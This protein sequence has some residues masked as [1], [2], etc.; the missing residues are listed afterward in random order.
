MECEACKVHYPQTNADKVRSMT[1]KQLAEL[2]S[3]LGGTEQAWLEWLREDRNA[4]SN[5]GD[6]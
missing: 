6:K 5:S 2:F 1:D 4:K 3:L